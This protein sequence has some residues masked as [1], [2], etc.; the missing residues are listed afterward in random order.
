[1]LKVQHIFVCGHYGC[2]GIKAALED[3]ELGLIDNWLC[4]IQ[5]MC[6]SKAKKLKGLR[7]D[8]KLDLLCELNVEEQVNNVCN[9]TIVRNAWKRKEKLSVHGWIYN[10]EN[11]ILRD[12]GDCISSSEQ[13]KQ[14]QL[15]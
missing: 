1:V 8:E 2:G 4:H 15:R 3:K 11:G 10:I 14:A 9:T 5:D 12:L 13:L 7:H 6:R